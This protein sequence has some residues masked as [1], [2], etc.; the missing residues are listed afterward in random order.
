MRKNYKRF[1]FRETL[2]KMV[3]P[4]MP[5]DRLRM[6]ERIA[7]YGLYGEEP[8]LQGLEYVAWIPM[9]TLIDRD[10]ADD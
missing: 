1:T 8:D 3:Q 10:C 4:L 6:L 2:W 9:K 5:G 7:G